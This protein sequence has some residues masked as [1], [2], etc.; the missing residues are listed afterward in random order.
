MRRKIGATGIVVVA[1][2]GLLMTA[3][4]AIV[5]AKKEGLVE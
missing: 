4:A 3:Y 5:G 1:V 2:L